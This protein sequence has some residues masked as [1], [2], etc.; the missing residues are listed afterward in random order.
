MDGDWYN[1]MVVKIYKLKSFPKLDE[2][3]EFARLVN[4][5]VERG[6]K[7]VEVFSR[8]ITATGKRYFFVQSPEC[9][10]DKCREI[11][12]E[13][14]TFNEVICA[15]RACNLYVDLDVSKNLNESFDDNTAESVMVDFLSTLRDEL[16]KLGERLTKSHEKGLKFEESFK[17]IILDSSRESK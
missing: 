11:P 16:I 2:A 12:T 9:F 6:N 17:L 10:F 8:E 15:D 1:D 14:R 13:W 3:I 5:G 7:R 4:E